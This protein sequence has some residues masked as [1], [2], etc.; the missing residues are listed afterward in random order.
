MRRRRGEVI[1]IARPLVVSA[2]LRRAT[3]RRRHVRSER[4]TEESQEVGLNSA[5]GRRS[6]RTE[7]ASLYCSVLTRVIEV[8]RESSTECGQRAVGGVKRVVCEREHERVASSAWLNHRHR[9]G[10]VTVVE[11]RRHAHAESL[12]LQLFDSRS[13]PPLPGLNPPFVPFP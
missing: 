8:M 13:R 5:G 10:L 2:A 4:G 6:M 3:V 7:L 9:L 12:R 11:C 1:V